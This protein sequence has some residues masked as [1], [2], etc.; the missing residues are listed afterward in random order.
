MS[1]GIISVELDAAPQPC[2]GFL[3]FSEL[4][5]SHSGEGRPERRS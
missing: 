5:L 1:G 4:E 2:R 3:V